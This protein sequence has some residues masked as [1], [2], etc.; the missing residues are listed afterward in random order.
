M[1][2]FSMASGRVGKGYEASPSTPG[3]NSAYRMSTFAAIGGCDDSPDVGA[4]ADTI[5][6]RKLRNARR[7]TGVSSGMHYGRGSTKPASTA[8]SSTSSTR[9]SVVKHLYGAQLDTNGDRFLGVY[10]QGRLVESSWRDFDENEGYRDRREELNGLAE[11]EKEDP[12]NDIDSI[13]ARIEREISF[14]GTEWHPQPG[15]ISWALGVY[16]GARRNGEDAFYN[17]E[18]N[19]DQFQFKFTDLGKE[20]LKNRLT[21]DTSGRFDPFG[22]RTRRRLYGELSPHSSRNKLPVARFV[23]ALAS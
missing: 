3:A 19:K 23:G 8:G 2:L 10:R 9:R 4:G 15:L 20:W 11:N 6:G 22:S 5:V 12:V 17:L 7:V 21:R 16:F 14:L 18:W 13:A 1:M